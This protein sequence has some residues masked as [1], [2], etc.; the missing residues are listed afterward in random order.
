MEGLTHWLSQPFN[1]SQDA[2]SWFLFVGLI[3]IAL[4]LWGIILNDIRG[5][6]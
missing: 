3:V 6:V 1:Q 4:T 2:F 5:V